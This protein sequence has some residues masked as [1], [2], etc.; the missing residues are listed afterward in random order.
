MRL[1]R[2]F[3]ENSNFNRNKKSAPKGSCCKLILEIPWKTFRN[4]WQC[5]HWFS[6]LFRKANEILN[7][8]FC[9]WSIACVTN[10]AK[11]KVP[12][13]ETLSVVCVDS[14]DKSWNRTSQFDV[15]ALEFSESYG[16]PQLAHRGKRN[17]LNLTSCVMTN[18]CA[19]IPCGGQFCFYF[20]TT[21]VSIVIS[22]LESQSI[23]D[24]ASTDCRQEQKHFVLLV[25]HSIIIISWGISGKLK[26]TGTGNDISTCNRAVRC[27]CDKRLNVALSL[28]MD[29]QICTPTIHLR[30]VSSSY[31]NKKISWERAS[32]IHTWSRYGCLRVIIF[33]LWSN[34]YLINLN[35]SDN[36]C[37]SPALENQTCDILWKMKFPT[38]R[39]TYPVERKYHNQRKLWVRTGAP[40]VKGKTCV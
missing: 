20:S 28:C 2:H 14:R 15:L 4:V 25:S 26:S 33:D 23:R 34:Q 9:N 11:V 27:V 39:V 16:K 10:C 17:H 36:K 37:V 40:N 12:L 22:R 38:L 35:V 7:S 3:T 19:N 1:R 21:Y 30:Q 24:L 18:L 32:S 8:Q 29:C 6:A 5:P 13:F 31:V